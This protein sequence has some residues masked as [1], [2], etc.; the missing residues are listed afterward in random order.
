MLKVRNLR[1]AFGHLQVLKGIDF[2]IA[3][4]QVAFIIG[5]SGGGKTTLL[6]CLNFLEVPDS[7]SVEIDRLILCHEDE[8]GF[9]KLPERQLRT[10]RA[11]MPMVFQHFNLWNH[12][13][14]LENV[15]EG[16]VIVQH[17]PRAEAVEEASQI[18]ADVGLGD[19]LEAYPAELSGG[20]KQRVGIARALAM[21]PKLLLFDEPTSSLDP[22]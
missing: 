18:L 15:I 13:T 14:V 3:Q 16:P 17:R 21:R 6:R 7:G 9:H 19:K 11:Q 8:R 10:A 2:E 5:P 20:Q 12:R 1:K 4:G 22:E